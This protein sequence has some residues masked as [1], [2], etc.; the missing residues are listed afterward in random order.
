MKGVLILE[1]GRKFYGHMLAH[2]AAVGEV[3]FNTGMTGYQETFTD[4]SYAGQIITMTYPLIGNYGL[5]H[6]IEQANKPYANGFI[7]SELCDM[8]SNWQNEGTLSTFIMTHHIPCLYGVDTRAITRSIRQQGVMK[9]VIV[10]ADMEENAVKELF[11]T[12][13]ETQL[14]QQVTTRTIRH[15]GSGRFHV[16]VMDYGAKTNILKDLVK[17]D[18]RLTVFPAATKAEDVLAINPDGIFLSNGPGDPKDVPHIVNE[19]KKMI[20]QKPIF[21]ICLGLQML[22]LALG[23]TSRKL[24]FGHRGANHPVKDVCTGRV[25]ITSQNHGYVIDEDSLPNNVVVTHRNLHDNTLEGFK[26][27]EMNIMCVQY[28]PEASPG[29]TDNLYL[30]EQ[31]IKMME[32]K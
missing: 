5:F 17:N 29:P 8:P 13:L 4:P 1:N 26:C 25:Y 18:C 3:V 7:V 12:P 24:T 31:F 20:G 10:P 16:A 11:D 2:E 14:V 27:P 15:Q 6:E 23:G 21:G 9:G 19:V 30:F 28:H 22:G 32:G